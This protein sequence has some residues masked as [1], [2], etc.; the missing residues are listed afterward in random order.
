[1]RL[2]D[3][4]EIAPGTMRTALSR[5]VKSGEVEL[6]EGRYRLGD[7]LAS[8]QRSQD[9][10][11]HEL[12]GG[13]DGR[14]H[15]IVPIVDQRS[16]R[17]RRRFRATMTD[18]HFGALRADIWMRPANLPAPPPTDPTWVC[19]TGT[20]DGA[21]PSDLVERLWPLEELR[22]EAASLVSQLG[23]VR[24]RDSASSIR[25]LFLVAADS[26][27]CLRRDPLLP[28]PIAPPRWP[29]SELRR[30]YALTESVLQ[31]RLR[32]LFGRGEPSV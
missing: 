8:R 3:E 18:A 1:M 24:S 6:D 2:A 22:A 12:P 21:N 31:A 23:Q 19:T 32:Q 10:A 26:L 5:L 11:R 17:E 7:K 15:T 9:I 29:M 14:W 16:Q 28:D 25:S 30:Q 13:W 4:F 20:L 27:R